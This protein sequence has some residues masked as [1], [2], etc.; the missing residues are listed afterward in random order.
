MTRLHPQ[1]HVDADTALECG[2]SGDQL[3]HV[4]ECQPCRDARARAH[5]GALTR[6]LCEW[7]A[8]AAEGVSQWPGTL[9]ELVVVAL[10]DSRVWHRVRLR[11]EIVDGS[12]PPASG[13]AVPS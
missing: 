8:D 13:T 1:G 12:V 9:D 5:E 11:V 2:M 6:Q 3:A 7:L 4:L 10:D